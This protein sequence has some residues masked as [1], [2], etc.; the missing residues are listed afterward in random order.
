MN[1]GSVGDI[2]LDLYLSHDD[3]LDDDDKHLE[4]D[5]SSF[6]VLTD[7]YTGS[8]GDTTTPVSISTDA[9]SK[10]VRNFKLFAV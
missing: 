10:L 7:G 9:G 3:M 2:A 8:S 5:T 4:F 6:S 1:S